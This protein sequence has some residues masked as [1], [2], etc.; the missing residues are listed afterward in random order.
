M[1]ILYNTYIISLTESH[2]KERIEDNEINID[3]F[4]VIRS[5]RDK[6]ICGGVVV[7]VRHDFTPTKT[8]CKSNQFC[9]L[10]CTYIPEINTAVITI[11]HPPKCSNDKFIEALNWIETWLA[12]LEDQNINPIILF[13]GDFNF[14]HMKGWDSDEIDNL[15]GNFGVRKY[16]N[17]T[18]ND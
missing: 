14:P 17:T 12:D 2:L 11:Y 6:R 10:L 1:S 13:N 8:I 9:E 4:Q 5:D 15:I 7:Y 18:K 3:N 16:V